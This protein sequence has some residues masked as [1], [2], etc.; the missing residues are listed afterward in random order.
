M[1]DNH[2]FLEDVTGEQFLKN[3]NFCVPSLQAAAGG[4]LDL[5]GLRLSVE[6]GCLVGTVDPRSIY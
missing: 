5:Q 2:F 3:E 1:Q 6:K 4:S